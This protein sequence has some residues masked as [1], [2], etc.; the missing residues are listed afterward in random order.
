MSVPLAITNRAATEQLH[1]LFQ[2]HCCGNRGFADW[3]S[4]PAAILGEVPL[5]CCRSD[6]TESECK[7]ALN[8]TTSVSACTFI[9]PGAQ[10]PIYVNGC[11]T[12]ISN[13]LRY[14][15][16]S[17]AGAAIGF[18]V[19]E[20]SVRTVFIKSSTLCCGNSPTIKNSSKTHSDSYLECDRQ[21]P[22]QLE[23]TSH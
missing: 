3:V 12:E 4:L 6:I 14:A 13:T 11:G 2:A 9:S 8:A 19:V 18:A 22:S 7:S 21:M 1:A 15:M 5:S 23:S 16:A 10:C 17:V 20:V